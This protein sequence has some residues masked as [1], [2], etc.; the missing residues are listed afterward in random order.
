M[1]SGIENH[2]SGLPETLKKIKAHDISLNDAV[3]E[4]EKVRDNIS[5]VT[6]E[7]GQKAQNNTVYLKFKL[8]NSFINEDEADLPE[9]ITSSNC[10][11]LYILFY[12]FSR[13]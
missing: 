2:F 13:R 5:L 8:I 3:T 6:G 7:V 1:L 9:E 12:Y 11:K 10:K 4:I